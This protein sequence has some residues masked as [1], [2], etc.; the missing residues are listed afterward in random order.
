MVLFEDRFI[1][2]GI[3][4]SKYERVTRITAKSTGFDAEIVLDVNSDLFPVRENTT[5]H[6]L[7]TNNLSTGDSGNIEEINDFGSLVGNYEYAMYGKIIKFQIQ[8]NLFIR[9]K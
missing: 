2:R 5:L 7:L 1:V 4:N 9:S 8:Y 6:I 3:D